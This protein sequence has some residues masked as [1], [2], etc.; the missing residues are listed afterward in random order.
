MEIPALRAAQRG[1]NVLTVAKA[2]EFG[3]E[4]CHVE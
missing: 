2:V 4:G 3:D 1:V